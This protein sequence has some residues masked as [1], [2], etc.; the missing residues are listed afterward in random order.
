MTSMDGKIYT[1]EGHY[2][3]YVRN[4][5][6]PNQSHCVRQVSGSNSFT[7]Y[8]WVHPARI[9]PPPSTAFPESATAKAVC[10]E[11]LNPDVVAMKSAKDRFE[12]TTPV[13]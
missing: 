5:A 13:G 3:A 7:P 12:V 6:A 8:K 10:T 4:S 2:V 11:N 1:S 9:S